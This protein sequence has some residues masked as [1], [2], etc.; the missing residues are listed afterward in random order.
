MK[1]L[2]SN[3][4]ECDVNIRAAQF[5]GG[6]TPLHIATEK[7]FPE[8][9]KLLLEFDETDVDVKDSRGVQTPLLLAIKAKNEKTAQ[10]LIENGASL[11]IKA[12]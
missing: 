2:L 9:M 7:G 5:K 8:C 12:G 10:M 3:R 4:D 11:D 1:L 6:Y